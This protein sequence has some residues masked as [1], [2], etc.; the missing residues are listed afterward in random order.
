MA[1]TEALKT[2]LSRD[3]QTEQTV[4]AIRMLNCLSVAEIKLDRADRLSEDSRIEMKA[5]TQNIHS[6]TDSLLLGED[7]Q[8]NLHIIERRV[9]QFEQK[10]A[11]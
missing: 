10:I 9:T 4:S 1:T 5:I 3:E 8:S 2:E 7:V 6:L 11:S